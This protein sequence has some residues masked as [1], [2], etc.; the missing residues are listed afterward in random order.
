MSI[1]LNTAQTW[2]TNADLTVARNLYKNLDTVLLI[3]QTAA[4]LEVVHAAVGLVKSNPFLVF[5]QVLSRITVVWLVV[6]PFEA[7]RSSIGL[8]VCCTAW[9]IAEIVRYVYYALNILNVMP[10]FVAWCRYSFFIIL[11]PVGVT[12]ELICIY[13]AVEY[14]NP[15]SIRKNYSL[16]LP[17][18]YN[19]SFDY[20]YFLIFTMLVYIPCNLIFQKKL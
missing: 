5:L 6:Y 2:K 7:S 3:V 8:V 15:L 19:V 12:G 17:N 9:P 16:S 1:T 14:L 18:K 11:Y 10:F 4:L 13:K 20:Q